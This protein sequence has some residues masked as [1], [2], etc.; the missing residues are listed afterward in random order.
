MG[1]SKAWL[2]GLLLCSNICTLQTPVA[3]LFVH[4]LSICC[5]K[6]ALHLVIKVLI[7]VSET[8][9]LES[10]RCQAIL[11]ACL[12]CI[13]N[14]MV[15][16]IQV[17]IRLITSPSPKAIKDKP[18]Q[19][20]PEACPCYIKDKMNGYHREILFIKIHIQVSKSPPTRA[21]RGIIVLEILRACFHGRR[22]QMNEPVVILVVKVCTQVSKYLSLTTITGKVVQ[23][24]MKAHVCCTRDWK[25]CI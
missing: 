14:S 3:V 23:D 8:P 13:R 22:V 4:S 12:C 21:I 25:N 2:T 5:P 10:I 19:N 20:V 17:H 1:L 18:M 9:P 7:P 6:T 16:I 11:V 24:C 15:V